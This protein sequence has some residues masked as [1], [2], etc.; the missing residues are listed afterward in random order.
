MSTLQVKAA[1]G[2]SVPM[3]D[4]PRVYIYDAEPVSVPNSSYYQ[5]R[6][7]DGDLI[8]QADQELQVAAASADA[9]ADGKKSRATSKTNGE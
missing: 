1:P 9:V 7:S 3:E 6:I 5:R 4:K 8:E 2:L